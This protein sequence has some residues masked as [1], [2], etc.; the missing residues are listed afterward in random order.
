MLSYQYNPERYVVINPDSGGHRIVDTLKE[1]QELTRKYPTFRYY[2]MKGEIEVDEG[3]IN[4]IRWITESEPNQ[5]T[6]PTS[7]A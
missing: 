5:T 7:G 4:F 6:S 3:L 2:G 1:A